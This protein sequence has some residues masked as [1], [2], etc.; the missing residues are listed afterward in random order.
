MLK[1]AELKA[2]G[3]FKRLCTYAESGGNLL[4]ICGGYQMMG[5]FVHDPGGLEDKP[6]SPEG[7]G[8]L[9]AG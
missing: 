4:G 2:K 5:A 3:W 7:L 9:S 8:L 6:V 1:F